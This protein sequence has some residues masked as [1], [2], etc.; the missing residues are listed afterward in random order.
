MTDEEFNRE[1]AAMRETAQRH[2]QEFHRRMRRNLRVTFVG[3]VL[4]CVGL[5]LW[6]ALQVRTAL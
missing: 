6:I 3:L 5:V 2:E 4:W 1:L